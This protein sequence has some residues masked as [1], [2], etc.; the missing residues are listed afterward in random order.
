MKRFLFIVFGFF[1][2]LIALP[3][4]AGVLVKAPASSSVYYISGDNR[5]VFPNDQTY[6]SWYSDYS[7]I[8]SVTDEQLASLTLAGN[9]TYR[10]GKRLVKVQTD[11]KVYAVSE[12]GTLRWIT[13]EEVAA[14]LYGSNWGQQIDDIPD[15][16]F[17]NYKV[18]CCFWS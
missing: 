9:V 14:T 4:S 11:P 5:Y 16:F 13:T 18:G 8:T 7:A 2:I 10:P 17:T 15:V 6:K 1:F 3:A 12:N